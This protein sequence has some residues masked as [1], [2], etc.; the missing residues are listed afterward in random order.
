MLYKLEVVE[1][2]FQLKLAP[3]WSPDC[4]VLGTAI[5]FKRG[6][7]AFWVPRGHRHP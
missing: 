4:P 6:K 1:I 7:N 5:F 2:E 3:P